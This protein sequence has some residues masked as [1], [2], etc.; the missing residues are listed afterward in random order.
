MYARAHTDPRPVTFTRHA[1]CT[2]RK[3]HTHKHIHVH[4][5][6]HIHIHIHIHVHIQIHIHIP[7]PCI[8]DTDENVAAESGAFMQVLRWDNVVRL[9]VTGESIMKMV[10]DVRDISTPA[11]LQSEFGDGHEDFARPGAWQ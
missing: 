11:G 6:V 3:P 8:I 5:H 10:R 7:N 2:C 4:I 9:A 1:R